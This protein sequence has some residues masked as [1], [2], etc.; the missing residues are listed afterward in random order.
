MPVKAPSPAIL[1]D[2][3]TFRENLPPDYPYEKL[4]QAAWD[5]DFRTDLEQVGVEGLAD[6]SVLVT[7]MVHIGRKGEKL[8]PYRLVSMHL[9]SSIGPVTLA[10]RLQVQTTL[11]HIFFGRLPPAPSEQ[12]VDVG[13]QPEGDIKLPGE[14]PLPPE[15]EPEQEYVDAPPPRRGP[16]M[17]SLIDHVEPD[18][19]PVFIDLDDVPNDFT[20][21][22]IVEQFL[23]DV[24]AA[25]VKFD[26]LAQLHALYTKNEMAIGFIKDDQVASDEDR[27]KLAD[28]MERH[29]Q[30]IEAAAS[31]REVRIP[32]GKGSTVSRRRRAAA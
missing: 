1:D 4:L 25:A 17:P 2:W 5:A 23:K 14:D 8:E 24:D 29:S 9:L 27:Q 15:D 11:V 28:L 10:A 31:P 12:T 32:G 18:G 22:Q 7:F 13:R 26:S 6:A 21:A 30:R 16:K 20:S 3:N 19:V